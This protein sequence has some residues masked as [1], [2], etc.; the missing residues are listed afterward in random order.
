MRLREICMASICAGVLGSGMVAEAQQQLPDLGEMVVIIAYLGAQNSHDI[1]VQDFIKD[2][3]RFIPIF[4][5]QER[6]RAELLGSQYE[7]HG[8][9]VR[10][11]LLVE[12]LTGDEVLILHPA[13]EAIRLSRT[14]LQTILRS[15]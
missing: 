8:V 1:K 11:E 14:D 4:V 2:G 6:F 13:A 3:E 9:A 5:D 12:L 15:K 7:A 10:L